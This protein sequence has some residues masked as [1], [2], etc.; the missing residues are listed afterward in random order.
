MIPKV[1]NSVFEFG[2]SYL[3]ILLTVVYQISLLSK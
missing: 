3:Q 1:R 2:F